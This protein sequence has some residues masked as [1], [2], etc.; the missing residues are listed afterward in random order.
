MQ[1]TVTFSVTDIYPTVEIEAKDRDEAIGFY[2]DLW[3]QGELSPEIVKDV[4]WRALSTW[5][6]NPNKK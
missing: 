5:K 3:K 1:Y 2:H 6:T 4:Q